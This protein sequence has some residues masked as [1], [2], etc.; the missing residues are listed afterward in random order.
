MTS[1]PTS[2]PT[3]TDSERR[4]SAATFVEL[5]DLN[6][7]EHRRLRRAARTPRPARSHGDLGELKTLSEALALA[8]RS[9]AWTGRRR[10][11]AHGQPRRARDRRRRRARA[12]ATPVSFYYTLTEDSRLRRPDCRTKVAFVDEA[13][14][15]MWKG[16]ARTSSTSPRSWS[17]AR[18]AHIDGAITFEALLARGKELFAQGAASLD[19]IAAGDPG[20]ATPR[21]SSTPRARPARPRVRCSTHG[22]LLFALRADPRHHRRRRRQACRGRKELGLLD[23]SGKYHYPPGAAMASYLPLAHIAERIFSL[24]HRAARRRPT[25]ASSATSRRWPRCCRRS[26]RWASSPYPGSG[27]SSTRRSSPSSRARAG[28]SGASAC[29]RSR[30]PAQWAS[31]WLERARRRR[32]WH[33]QHGLF[34]QTVYGKL[35]GGDRA[36]PDRLGLTGAAPITKDLLA[37]WLGFGVDDQRGVRHD[38]V[39]RDPGVHPA[40]RAARRHRRQAA[41]RASR[42]SSPTTA[43]CSCAAPTSSR[44]YLRHPRRPPR[45]ATTA[46]CT[47][48][49]WR[50]STRRATKIVDRKKEIIITAAGKNIAPEQHREGDQDQSPIIGQRGRLRR[51]QPYRDRVGRARPGGPARLRGAPTAS[52]AR[53]AAA[54]GAPGRAGRGRARGRGGQ[55]RRWPGSSRSRSGRARAGVDLRLRR[56]GPPR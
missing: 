21:R 11:P 32:C 39:A 9:S 10:R 17:S 40:G 50:R 36:R 44:G 22:G 34:E 23:E 1:T 16:A 28:R 20:A 25:S 13:L 55:R 53:L 47:P 6:A 15:P 43:S 19:E 8:L 49:T 2:T 18:S 48:V 45:P 5:Q 41:A 42:P 31:R 51:R 35:A 37:T 46:G 33:L 26:G 24:L 27:R 54:R 38:R 56:A 30:S 3:S 14:L 52:R 7:E 29:A 12:G 4:R